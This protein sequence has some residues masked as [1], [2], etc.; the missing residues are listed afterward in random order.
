MCRDATD[1]I[2]TLDRARLRMRWVDSVTSD[3]AGQ[4]VT[5]HAR[6]QAAG[7]RIDVADLLGALDEV[8]LPAMSLHV[9]ADAEPQAKVPGG[10][11]GR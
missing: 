2:P 8:G 5:V 9:L 10:S 1:R 3:R 7:E 11:A 4:K 6:Y